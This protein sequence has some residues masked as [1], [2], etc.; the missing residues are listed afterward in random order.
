[1]KKKELIIEFAKIFWIFIIGSIAGYLFETI[2]V[3][4]QRGH[5]EIRQGLIYGPF[6]P[7]YGIGAI[8]YYISFKV[9]KTKNK[10]NVFLVC[11][12]LGGITEYLCSYIQEKVFHSISWDYSYLYFNFNGRT[13]LLHSCYWGIA[14]ILYI[15]YIEPMI[16]KIAKIMENKN[17]KIITVIAIFIIICDINISCMAVTRQ[18]DRQNNVEP[19][20]N[21]EKFLDNHY[22]DEYIDKIFS[23]KKNVV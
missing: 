17:M 13:S 2:I 6:I 11:M 22:P 23:N 5:F 7:V 12:I 21:I 20:N 10:V 4:L 1:M 15:T 16:C 18:R 3:L 9:L 19:R 14:G 8:I